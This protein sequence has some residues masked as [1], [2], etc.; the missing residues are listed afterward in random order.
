MEILITT[1]ITSLTTIFGIY[2]KHYLDKRK[3]DQLRKDA[4]EIINLR[5]IHKVSLVIKKFSNYKYTSKSSMN[6]TSLDNKISFEDENCYISFQAEG[7]LNDEC[8]IKT[9][10]KYS[11]LITRKLN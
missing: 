8:E 9:L 11:K 2:F 1:I 6:L 5:K 4:E 7:E 3:E 10:E